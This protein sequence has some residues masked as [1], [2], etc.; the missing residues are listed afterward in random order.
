MLMEKSP[1]YIYIGK[2]KGKWNK[3]K[4]ILK[5]DKYKINY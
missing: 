2:T 4:K 3:K 5:K 1:F